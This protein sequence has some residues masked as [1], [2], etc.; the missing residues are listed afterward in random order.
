MTYNYKPFGV[1]ARNIKVSLNGDIIESVEFEGGCDGNLK[2]ISKLV[3]GMRA[4]ELEALL[5]N[6]RCG[7]KQSSCTAQLVI[8]IKQAL[9]N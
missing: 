6:N 7:N 8:A 5:G 4:A 9:H 2:A 3:V 1:C